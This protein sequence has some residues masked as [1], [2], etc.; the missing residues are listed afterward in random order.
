MGDNQLAM[1]PKDLT[2]VFDITL[3]AP[4]GRERHPLVYLPTEAVRQ[5]YYER[6]KRNGLTVVQDRCAG[7]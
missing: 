1:N 4:D 5:Q 3:T 6:A 7:K 2:R